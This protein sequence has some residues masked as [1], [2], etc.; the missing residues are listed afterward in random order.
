MVAPLGPEHRPAAGVDRARTT[1]DGCPPCGGRPTDPV[2]LRERGRTRCLY[3]Q[4]VDRTAGPNREPFRR[5]PFHGVVT[6]L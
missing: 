5:P 4:R 6:V 2:V 1:G 3:A